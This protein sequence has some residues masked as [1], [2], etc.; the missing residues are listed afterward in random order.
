MG[1]GEFIREK[2]SAENLTQ[3]ALGRS[4][5]V[6]GRTVGNWEAGNTR[7]VMSPLDMYRLCLRLGVTLEQLAKAQQGQK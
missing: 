3:E 1:L 7:P 2:R 6:S 4:V 5:G